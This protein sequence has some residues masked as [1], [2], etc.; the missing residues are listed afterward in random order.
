MTLQL[1]HVGR[2]FGSQWAIR[3]VSAVVNGGTSVA[4]LGANGAGKSTLLRCIAGWLPLAAGRISIEG[5]TLR[6]NSVAV[7]RRLMLLDEP[8]QNQSSAIETIVQAVEDYRV[9]R[10]GIEAEVAAWMEK[11][12]LV[13]IYGKSCSAISK[14]QQY[15]V[16]MIGLFVVRPFVWLL[17]E[18]FSAGLDAGGLGVL[19]SEMRTHARDGGIVLFSSQWPEHANRLADEAIVL[20]EGSLVCRHAINGPVPDQVIAA[21]APS[22]SAVLSGLGKS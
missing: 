12:D 2:N 11:L 14:G 19:E 17:D 16:A 6:P 4:V 22:L 13:G 9:D 15:K 8:R 21:A 5:Y 3:D 7:R 1:N 18:P 10:R 20:H